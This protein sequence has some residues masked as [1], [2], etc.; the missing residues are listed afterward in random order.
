MELCQI[1]PMLGSIWALNY[2]VMPPYIY[3]NQCLY[4]LIITPPFL[5][6]FIPGVVLSQK[7]FM[8]D[9]IL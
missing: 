9:R 1:A 5:D 2:E 3:F 7:S 6:K 4:F 8:F